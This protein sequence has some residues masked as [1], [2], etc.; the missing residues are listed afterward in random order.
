MQ[1]LNME[2]NRLRRELRAV[3]TRLDDERIRTSSLEICDTITASSIWK[4]CDI[5]LA[6]MAFPSG[7][8][9]IDALIRT[10]L[11]EKRRVYV[12]RVVGKEMQFCVP[13]DRFDLS[14]YGIREPPL[15]SVEL[16]L[17]EHSGFTVLV[18]I[19]GMAFDR[20]KRRLGRGGGYYDRFLSKLEG[21][22]HT[23][24]RLGVCFH[25]QLVS[26]VPVGSRD[27]PVHGVV[28]DGY[29]DFPQNFTS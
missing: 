16:K 20:K 6:Y 1:D 17:N 10:A 21:G 22:A 23:Q 29:T 18:V 14:P 2:K 12:P 26:A 4:E 24:Y 15:G 5:I 8:V 19:P 7:E 25:E 9:N 27:I 11:S 13:G 28:S 3:L